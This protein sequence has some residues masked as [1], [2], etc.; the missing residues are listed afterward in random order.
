MRRLPLWFAL[1]FVAGLAAVAAAWPIIRTDTDLWYHLTAGR[2][3]AETGRIP[4]ESFF[5]FLAPPR[6]Y[7]DYY[8]LFQR[9]VYAVFSRFDYQGLVLLRAAFIAA[10]GLGVLLLA[11]G[12]PGR[13][14]RAEG[15]EEHGAWRAFLTTAVLLAILPRCLVLRPHLAEY[16]GIVSFLVVLEHR[17]GWA[18]VL[19]FLAVLWTNLHGISYPVLLLVCGAY[20]GERLLRTAWKGG[21][22][23]TPPLA[24]QAFG[25]IAVAMAAA[26]ITPFGS[27]LVDV[28]FRASARS[29]YQIGELTPVAWEHLASFQVLA[30]AV[31]EESIFAVLLILAVLAA[32]GSLAERRAR[33]AHLLL[34]AGGLVLLTRGFRLFHE[35]AFLSLPLLRSY[36]PFSARGRTRAIQWLAA[37]GLAALAF[38]PLAR[39]ALDR[40]AYPFSRSGLPDGVTAFLKAE[41]GGGRVF[42]HPNFGGFYQWE[43]YPRFRIY[44]D[45][46]TPFLFSEDDVFMSFDA[47]SDSTTLRYFVTEYRPEFLVAE[48]GRTQFRGVVKHFPEYEPVFVDG[49]GVLYASSKAR[50]ELVKR[51]R[52]P[53]DPFRLPDVALDDVKDPPGWKRCEP[54]FAYRMLEVAPENPVIRVLAAKACLSR[55]DPASAER[56]ARVLTGEFREYGAG[57]A[58]LGESLERQGR[59]GEAV[60]AYREAL[61][62]GGAD[63]KVT[64]RRLAELYRRLGLEKEAERESR[65][66]DPSL[67]PVSAVQSGLG[68]A[69]GR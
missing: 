29:Q 59:D 52:L 6:P 5:S 25:L 26:F 64:H 15:D 22:R 37:L 51:W 56:H 14:A 17:P 1:A 43:L 65:L 44:A 21:T 16:L 8:W 38:A 39:R 46:Q 33:A 20:V 60:K 23:G 68:G 12:P 31:T 67:P 32:A 24:D 49:T 9:L 54:A 10:I 40:P 28:P 69:D 18:F 63:P 42:H 3:M 62:R 66:V 27:D 58:I 13:G 11:F 61:S 55:D 45:M 34:L 57:F 48:R 4:A 30:G 53:V 7:V 2:L 47:F 35:F 50:P 41:G 19:P 36:P